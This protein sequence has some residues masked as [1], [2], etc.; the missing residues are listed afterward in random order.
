MPS[1]RDM[2]RRFFGKKPMYPLETRTHIIYVGCVSGN[3][4]RP[5][6][7]GRYFAD[8][9]VKSTFM[10]ENDRTLAQILLKFLPMVSINQ[11]HFVRIIVVICRCRGCWSPASWYHQAISSIILTTWNNGIL[12]IFNQENIQSAYVISTKQTILSEVRLNAFYPVR[13][14]LCAYIS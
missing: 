5:R 4:L 10:N 8:D 14:N 13:G 12:V 6:Q 7:N 9:S 3:I 11:Y 1:T 2:V